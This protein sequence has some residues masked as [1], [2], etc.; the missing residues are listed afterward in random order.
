MTD[1]KLHWARLENL[2]APQF[3]AITLARQ[4]VFIA[5]QHICCPDSDEHDPHCWHLTA[6]HDGKVAAY[7]RVVDPG[8]KYPEPS[9]GRVL[10]T[11]AYRR[12]GLGKRIMQVAI[13]NIAERYPGQAIRISAQAYLQPFYANLGFTTVSE[14]YLEEGVPHLE[15]LRF[16]DT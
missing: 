13:A 1:I 2:S 9:I 7:L 10:T 4:T 5:E 14:E 11:Q 8:E 3:H 15:M 12:T 6:L 16:S